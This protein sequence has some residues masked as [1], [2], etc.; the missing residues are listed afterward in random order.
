MAA[1]TLMSLCVMRCVWPAC[2]H[3]AQAVHGVYRAAD[4]GAWLLLLLLLQQIQYGCLP[5]GAADWLWCCGARGRLTA[6][7]RPP[8]AREPHAAAHHYCACLLHTALA[9][10]LVSAAGRPS[11]R[12]PPVVARAVIHAAEAGSLISEHLHGA[13][14]RGCHVSHIRRGQCTRRDACIEWL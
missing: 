3:V 14:G 7:R 11:S 9:K 4:L 5:A 8:G 1:S 13:M 10:A 2:W 6:A 12:P